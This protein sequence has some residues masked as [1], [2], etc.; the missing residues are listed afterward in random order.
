MRWK[1]KTESKRGMALYKFVDT[2][3]ESACGALS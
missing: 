2:D 1:E 3:T